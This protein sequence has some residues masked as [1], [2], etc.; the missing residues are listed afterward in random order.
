MV[1]EKLKLLEEKALPYLETFIK[2]KKERKLVTLGTIEDPELIKLVNEATKIIFDS[3][4]RPGDSTLPIRQQYATEALLNLIGG[5]AIRFENPR[6]L[7][8]PV[9]DAIVVSPKTIIDPLNKGKEIKIQKDTYLDPVS[10]IAYSKE[11]KDIEQ[12]GRA[13]L[14]GVFSSGTTSSF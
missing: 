6:I 5:Q 13:I 4:E 7:G 14:S 10:R 8:Q 2:N 1:L 11:I 9:S 3:Y 12:V